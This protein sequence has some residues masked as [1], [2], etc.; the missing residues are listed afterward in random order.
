MI[1]NSLKFCIKIEKGGI[2]KKLIALLLVIFATNIVFAMERKKTII[3]K[4][5][6]IPYWKLEEEAKE[7][8]KETIQKRIHHL[9]QALEDLQISRQHYINAKKITMSESEARKKANDKYDDLIDDLKD[10]LKT[11]EEYYWIPTLPIYED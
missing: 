4:R 7:S 2:M 10:E 11:A 5:K 8:S 9:T 1:Y 3:T 6:P